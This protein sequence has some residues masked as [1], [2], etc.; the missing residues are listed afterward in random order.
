MS[1]DAVEFINERKRMCKAGEADCSNCPLNKIVGGSCAVWCF[2]HPQE[3]VPIV[4]QWAREHPRPT[5]QSEFL[6]QW[7]NAS[8]VDGV[9]MLYPCC[10]DTELKCNLCGEDKCTECCRE[11]WM[12][13]I[14]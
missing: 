10:V 2:A 9:L 1:M 11:F 5:R 12:Q 3:V 8:L 6:K 4:E 7:P 13:E 14:D